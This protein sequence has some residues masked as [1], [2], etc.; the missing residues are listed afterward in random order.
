MTA[1]RRLLVTGSRRHTD[2]A[3][4]RQGLREAGARLGRDTV[5][6]HGAATG[7]DALAAEVWARWGLP[8]EG[9]S[10][11]WTGPC[12][13]QCRS[14]HRKPRRDGSTYCPAAGNYRNAEMVRLGADLC[15][16]FPLG[17]SQGTRDCMEQAALA[18]IEILTFE[19]AAVDVA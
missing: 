1:P 9:H 5:L 15:V 3:L 11:D 4:I 17:R 19:R 10:A 12:R 6:V 14:G 13:P 16:A 8:V 18:G 2:G 7:A